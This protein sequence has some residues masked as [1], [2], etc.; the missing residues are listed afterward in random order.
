MV[1]TILEYLSLPDL[2]KTSN[3]GGSVRFSQTRLMGG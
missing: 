2:F 3:E 1:L